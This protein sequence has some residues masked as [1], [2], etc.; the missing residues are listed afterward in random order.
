M[1]GPSHRLPL[2][3]H[4]SGSSTG[5]RG[6]S[7]HRQAYVFLSPIPGRPPCYTIAPWSMDSPHEHP[8][9][10][11]PI[12]TRLRPRR[13]LCASPQC[14]SRRRMPRGP[15]TRCVMGRRAPSPL[16]QALHTVRVGRPRGFRPMDNVL[17]RNLFLFISSS[18]QI[19]N[20]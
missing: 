10:N 14:P 17:N 5:P 11:Q 6:C 1:D 19:E 18:I 20:S 7:L 8:P 2:S 12:V 16:V 15:S 9:V 4:R 13:A 3:L